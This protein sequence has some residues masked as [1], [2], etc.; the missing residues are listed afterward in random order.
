MKQIKRIC[1]LSGIWFAMILGCSLPMRVHAVESLLEITVSTGKDSQV[2]MDD[3]YKTVIKGNSGDMITIQATDDS[4]LHGIYI[5]WDSPVQPW[6][7]TTDE[8]ERS[9]GKYGY[10]HE[11]VALEEPS[12]QAII[13]IPADDMRICEIRGFGEGELPEDVQ[14][15]NPPCDKADIMIVASHADDDI[16]FFGGIVPTYGV[17]KG[18]Q[19]QV[20]FMT[21][22][23]TTT[24]IREHEK[25]DGL[26]V[27][28]LKNYPVS[29]DFPDKYADSLEQ[30]EQ[31]YSLEELTAFLVTQIRRFKPQVMVTHDLQGEYGHGYH[32][33]TAKAV[34]LAVEKALEETAYPETAETL[35]IWDV[36]KT[37]IHLYQENPITL[38][39]RVPIEEL[40]GKTA[41]EVAKEAYKQHVSQQWCWFY[42]SDDY[43]YSC[44]EFGLYRTTVGLDEKQ[45]MLDHI[46]LY[47]VQAEEEAKR[48]EEEIAKKAEEERLAAEEAARIAEEERIAREFEKIKK[49]LLER[50][51]EPRQLLEEKLVELKK[52]EREQNTQ[53]R[54][55]IIIAIGSITIGAMGSMIGNSVKK[56]IKKKK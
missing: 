16:L 40:G 21:E 14:V 11:Y 32:M 9:C 27:D 6:I 4:L 46:K 33:I 24:R 36:P 50:Q 18:A 25:L 20:V 3:N 38:D 42:V 47:R 19:V 31:I 56:S 53:K 39:L 44:A 43:K 34:N 48:L 2:L 23:W 7:L 51:E 41:L 26:W 49:Q 54:M 22:F 12:A 8:G 15:W 45:D 17:A 30:A 28:G 55:G 29:S 1:M 10:L 52:Q 37:Y 13:Q 5:I 35:G